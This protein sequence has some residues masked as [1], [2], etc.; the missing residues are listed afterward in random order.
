MTDRGVIKFTQ[1]DRD[2]LLRGAE[3]EPSKEKVGTEE[4]SQQD[5]LFDGNPVEE[6]TEEAV[7][8]AT[9]EPV[10]EEIVEEELSE[11]QE[12][13]EEEVGEE[14]E[15]ESAEEEVPESQKL[16]Q[17]LSE[18]GKK[19]L[20]E[21]EDPSGVKAADEVP[22]SDLPKIMSL[23]RKGVDAIT[24]LQN[25]QPIINEFKGSKILQDIYYY[26]QQG[27]SD[28]DIK[29]GL[30]QM[31]SGDGNTIE[32]EEPEFDT[33]EE[34]VEYLVQKRLEERLQPLQKQFQAV[35]GQR[36]AE[37]I[38]KHNGSVLEK[39]LSNVGYSPDQLTLAERTAID[40]SFATLY[41]GVDPTRYKLTPAQANVIV[42]DALSRGG[43]E[44]AQK[45]L[46]KTK[47]SNKKKNVNSAAKNAKATRTIPGRSVRSGSE[48]QNV[49]QPKI[50]S[51]AERRKIVND[52]F[53]DL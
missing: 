28:D 46:A 19:I 25:A 7:E 42:K 12:E 24:Y 9:E 23:A 3:E 48:P 29:K 45:T 40:N 33:I 35:E 50:V 37:T 22:V 17:E 27:Y 21:Y 49:F 10:E 8:G 34:K 41:P 18:E 11:E 52:L 53:K 39:A 1:A 31:W 43:V 6:S 16:F 51:E 15:E 2:E 44:K 5:E 47:P 30:V 14:E 13:T 4:G 36:T 26:R 32:E 38:M 20:V